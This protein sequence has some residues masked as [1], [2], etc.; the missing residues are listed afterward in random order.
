[1]QARATLRRAGPGLLVA[2]CLA[3]LAAT[4]GTAVAATTTVRDEGGRRAVYV[5]ANT[6]PNYVQVFQRGT[7]GRLTPD[8][9]YATGGAGQAAPGGG[10]PL[11]DSAGSVALSENGKLVFVVNSASNTVSSF[12]VHGGGALQ[13]ADQ[14]PTF[15][16]RPDSVTTSHGLV[17]VVNEDTANIAGY[18]VDKRGQ[19]TPIPGS[20][21][22]IVGGP[23][24]AQIKFN[25]T[26]DVLAVTERDSSTI[27]TFLI[28]KNGAAGPAIPNPATGSFP[29]G[30]DWDA[31]DHLFVSNENTNTVSSYEVTRAGTLTP[32]DE[33][34]TGGISPCWL[35]VTKD[36]KFAYVTNPISFNT[37]WMRI[38]HDGTVA[39]IGE[40]PNTGLSTDE[41]ISDD[42]RYLYVLVTDA[43][44]T[45]FEFGP[46]H[47]DQFRIEKD[48]SLTFLGTTAP[49]LP[50]SASGVAAY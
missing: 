6:A 50:S 24:A 27:S 33:E 3:A 7:D 11:L 39:R 43:D 46:A 9:Q 1:M 40:S 45:T 22:P 12:V 23:H 17:Y 18:D 14:E 48:G 42:N 15:G 26:G 35:V 20:V 34:P 25:R 8:G 36:N 49:I 4:G 44:F 16:D 32:I 30:F 29:F 28:D 19:L 41:D 2:A 38:E 31:R 10:L 13:L 37:V 21:R 47:L 5:Q